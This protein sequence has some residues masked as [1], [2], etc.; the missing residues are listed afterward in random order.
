MGTWFPIYTNYNGVP[1]PSIAVQLAMA[2]HC[3]HPNLKNKTFSLSPRNVAL[4][5]T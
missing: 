1:N 3:S 4:G 5:N 2:N